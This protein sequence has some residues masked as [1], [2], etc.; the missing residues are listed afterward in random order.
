VIN[1]TGYSAA[2]R[3]VAS[4][5]LKIPPH[6]SFAAAIRHLKMVGFQK[7][8]DLFQM[9]ELFCSVYGG[10]TF[11]ILAAKA[12]QQRVSRD[13]NIAP[14]LFTGK[15]LPQFRRGSDLL[16]SPPGSIKSK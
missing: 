9:V 15:N 3:P 7:W 6:S 10:S 8:S 2:K 4:R 11:R 12:R 5:R 13:S 16:M 14:R 1:G